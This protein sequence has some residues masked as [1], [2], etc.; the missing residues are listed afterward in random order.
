MRVAVEDSLL[1]MGEDGFREQ[2]FDDQ[3]GDP[4][5]P[6]RTLAV[7][8]G[9]FDAMFGGHRGD[10][11]R[12]ELGNGTRHPNSGPGIQAVYFS[13]RDLFAAKLHFMTE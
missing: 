6:E 5:A 1:L 2:G 7:D 3:R 10:A 9:D 12:A 13:Q 11:V 4:A 8:S